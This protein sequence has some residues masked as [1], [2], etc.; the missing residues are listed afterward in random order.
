MSMT[1]ALLTTIGGFALVLLAV[2]TIPPLTT[3]LRL[4]TATLQAGLGIGLGLL[5]LLGASG[6]ADGVDAV[7]APLTALLV[8]LA[9]LGAEGVLAIFLPPLLFDAALR[10]DTRLLV[11]DLVP[12]F[13]LA[14]VAV[15][16]TT[17][18]VAGGLVAVTTLPWLWAI[19]VGAVVATTDPSAVLGVFR[20][21][22]APRRLQALVEG[23]SLL[24]DAAA[25]VLV[26]AIVEV[27]R[28]AASADPGAIGLT[29]LWTFA[30][31][32]LLGAA[33]GWLAGLVVARLGNSPDA[34]LTVSLALPYL[35]FV[36]AERYLDASGIVAVVLSGLVL[37][38]AL[39]LRVPP[40]L[41][42]Q[43]LLLW[44]QLANWAGALVIVGATLLVPVTLRPQIFDL[45]GLG[46][47]IVACLTA[48]AVVLYGL[49]PG[50]AAA[51][52]ASPVSPRFRLAMLWGGLRGAV[53]VALAL[54]VAADAELPPFLRERVGVLACAF[55]LV[56]LFVQAPT[57][58][59][60]LR[61]LGL[62]GLSRLDQVM[63]E[64][65]ARAVGARL[66]D[67]LAEL[68]VRL[69]LD[70]SEDVIDE[71][72]PAVEEVAPLSETARRERIAAAVAAIT[73]REA[74]RY[75]DLYDEG[76]VGREAAAALLRGPRDLGEALRARGLAAYAGTAKRELTYDRG[77]RFRLWLYRTVGW[78]RPLARA[79]A[80]RYEV[81]LVR[82]SVLIGLRRD[83]SGELEGF[84]GEEAAERVDTLLG[85]RLDAHQKALDGLRHQYPAYAQELETRFLRRAGLR[86]ESEVY[87]ELQ[88]D[89]LLS[90][91]AGRALARQV[92]ER[93]RASDRLPALDL[94]LEPTALLERV[95]LFEQLDR[96]TRRRLRRALRP[97]LA[98]PGD[99]LIRR[100]AVGEAMYFIV[101]GA[102]AV[103]WPGGRRTLGTGDV[104]GETA[105]ITGRR[106]TADVVALTY[107][108]YLWLGRDDYHRLTAGLDSFGEEIARLA[109][110]R[111]VDR[112]QADVS[113]ETAPGD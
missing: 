28:G 93:R 15:V 25:I 99:R 79:L 30:G 48:R 29:F 55:V 3:R 47:V 81:V 39:D 11:A 62:G 36:G 1:G 83:V 60:L 106:R 66:A 76:I 40:A 41:G 52:I 113:R 109:R 14:V 73:E 35:A 9:D 5:V 17:F 49:I 44:G 94:R 4:P 16:L 56:T 18:F 65:A 38:H 104:F 97:G 45:V 6:L 13:L 105:L 42:R 26:A 87:R 57:L 67:R 86:L 84:M 108:Q 37:G 77:L 10:V 43:V 22:G 100:G 92:G 59:P 82:R 96:R 2:A 72:R 101:D 33:M 51:G 78:S 31:G 89:G 88:E 54:T 32:G 21:V 70:V 111:E 46:V 71:M 110:E 7:L 8:T 95:P 112:A 85:A 91:A 69:G 58:R 23:E 102:V 98:V 12:V 74:E 19:L 50:L 27:L 24:N 53:T 64:R 63:R 75:R 34:A 90:G 20:E 103:R 80:L 107:V 61:W 68:R